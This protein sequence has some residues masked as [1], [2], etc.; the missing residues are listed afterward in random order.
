MDKASSGFGEEGKRMKASEFLAWFGAMRASLKSFSLELTSFRL[1][2]AVSFLTR[3][4]A[5]LLPKPGRN[6]NC[7]RN[8]CLSVESNLKSTPS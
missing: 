6:C 1:G 7:E 2:K 5:F 8:S 3:K 4:L